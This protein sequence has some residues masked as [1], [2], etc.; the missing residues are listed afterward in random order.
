MKARR[1]LKEEA[2]KKVKKKDEKIARRSLELNASFPRLANK[3]SKTTSQ[4]GLKISGH[5]PRKSILSL[6]WDPSEQRNDICSS[7][8]KQ[9]QKAQ[10]RL[11][12]I[13][14]D[15]CLEGANQTSKTDSRSNSTNSLE[16]FPDVSYSCERL[17][18]GLTTPSQSSYEVQI[19]RWSVVRH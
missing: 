11:L 15:V 2:R 14:S 8:F 9:R 5:L 13:L 3:N 17:V 12:R 1:R 7:N 10:D 18:K 16:T 19:E 4:T 6:F